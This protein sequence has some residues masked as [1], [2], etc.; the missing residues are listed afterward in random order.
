[1]NKMFD[2]LQ[3][4]E[5]A[6]R[7]A[8][9]WIQVLAAY[10]TPSI[11]RSL[12]ELAI[13][14]L[15]FV[16]LWA[17]AWWSLQHSYFLAFAISLCNG[18]F[19]VRLFAI[20]HDCGHRSF[21]KNKDVGDWVGRA[22]GVLTVTPYDVWRRCHSEHH[23]ASGNLERQGMGDIVTKTV[24]EY[25]SMRP[26]QQFMY[27][28]YRHPIVLFA[29]GPTYLFI[30]QN[31]LPVGLMNKGAKYWSSAMGTNAAIAA[32]L[33]A[34]YYFGGWQPLVLVFLPSTI[35][36]A[37]LG[38]WLFYVQHQFEETHWNKAVDW[39]VHDAALEGSSHYDLPKVLHWFSANI[40]IHHVHHLY[41]RIPFYRLPQILKDHPVLA[42]SQRLGV[43]E[44]FTSV[45]LHLW[46]ENE[47]RLISYKEMKALYQ[48]A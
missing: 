19:L 15:P 37:T 12:F 45:K 24:E 9:E 13:T 30:F 34:I 48:N 44:S 25:L 3:A 27:R 29:L 33:G 17:L 26:R 6:V 18:G 4:Q 11:Q 46:D 39:D 36:A 47:R 14:I 35:L 43:W 22:L 10:R 38:V 20:Q 1:M 7:S 2:E 5:P 31:R 40:G 42:E 16:A 41:A 28:L 32:I 8:K 21:F 23:S